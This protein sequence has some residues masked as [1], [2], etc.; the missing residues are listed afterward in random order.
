MG[1]F[2][3]PEVVVLKESSDARDYLQKLQELLPIVRQINAK[4]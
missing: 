4:L 2:S 3:K 1:L